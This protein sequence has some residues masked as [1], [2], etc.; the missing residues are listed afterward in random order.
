MSV[1]FY[2][3]SGMVLYAS[4][5]SAVKAAVGVTLLSVVLVFVFFCVWSSVPM[6]CQHSFKPS[7][8]S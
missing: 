6:R 1:A 3:R 2:P 7:G 5:Q 4:E 8:Q